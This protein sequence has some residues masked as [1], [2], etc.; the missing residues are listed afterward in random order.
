LILYDRIEETLAA[1]P[2]V[3]G[4]GTTAIPLFYDFSLGGNFVVEGI[5]TAPGADTSSAMTAVGSG[6]FDALAQAITGSTSL[7]ALA[8]ST[9][10]EQFTSKAV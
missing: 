3:R 2:G 9:E 4:V 10:A 7:A 1:Q 6:Y 8:G 5:E